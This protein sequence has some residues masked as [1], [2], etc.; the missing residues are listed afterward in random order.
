MVYVSPD[1][2]EAEEQ[3]K[4]DSMILSSSSS[5]KVDEIA[6]STSKK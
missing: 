5:K 4:E 3:K 2:S 6:K 1:T